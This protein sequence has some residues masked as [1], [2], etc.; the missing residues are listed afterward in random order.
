MNCI[1]HLTRFYSN[2][3]NEFEIIERIT[4][5]ENPLTGELRETK[6]VQKYFII[7]IDRF[8]RPPP[9]LEFFAKRICASRRHKITTYGKLFVC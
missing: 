5:A 2:S 9:L 1:G 6:M 7:I 8:L 4:L 3:D